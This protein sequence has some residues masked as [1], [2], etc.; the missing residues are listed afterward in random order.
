MKTAG[1]VCKDPITRSNIIELLAQKGIEAIAIHSAGNFDPEI[2]DIFFV[3]LNSAPAFLVL[4][5]NTQ[6]CIAFTA[7]GDVHNIQKAKE[8][9]CEKVYKNGEFFKKILPNFSLTQ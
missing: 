8:L 1:I 5:R 3:D 9:G 2:F 7:S 4:A 6:K